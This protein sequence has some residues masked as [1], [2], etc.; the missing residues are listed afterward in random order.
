[1]P[2]H[3]TER[4]NPATDRRVE[5]RGIVMMS[6]VRPDSASSSSGSPSVD[7]G[8]VIVGIPL[9]AAHGSLVAPTPAAASSTAS[10]LS[11]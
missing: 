10:R 1:M 9:M 3:P 4:N 8:H 7:T 5:V 6:E 2:R 11:A